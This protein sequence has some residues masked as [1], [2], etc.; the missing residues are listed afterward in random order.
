ME[1]LFALEVP[2]WE[3][4]LRGTLV[5]WFLF[6]IFRF[7]VRRDVGSV[8]IAD[9]LLL[10]LIADASQNAMAG[11]YK[12]VSEGA[13]LVATIVS[14]NYLL[15]WASFRFEWVRRLAEPPPLPL[16]WRGRILYRNLRKEFLPVEELKAHLR[17]KGIEDLSQVKVAYMESDGSLSVIRR[18]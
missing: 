18:R 2:V 16:V 13:L 1:A 6:L 11:G 9:V 3:I 4:V 12:T 5:Y 8:A 14:W 17:Q 10:V 15:D 7:I